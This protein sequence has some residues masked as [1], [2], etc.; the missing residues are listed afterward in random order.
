VLAI[1]AAPYAELFA[2]ASLVV[3][4]AGIGTLAEAM[5]AGR[6]MVVMPYAH[7]QPDNA[8]RAVRLGVARQVSR[9]N[10]VAR[11]V[12]AL[13]DD[14]LSDRG[15]ERRA[16]EVGQQVRLEDGAVVAA[17]AI[18]RALRWEVTRS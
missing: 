6:A 1:P 17:D 16:A 5:R 10:Y 3:H 4:Q 18:F 11:G 12:A 7:D 8:A 2:A 9:R 15:M 14:V 13:I